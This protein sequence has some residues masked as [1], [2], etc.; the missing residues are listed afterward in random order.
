MKKLLILLLLISSQAYSCGIVPSQMFLCGFNDYK[1]I[2]Y[3]FGY[4]LGYYIYRDQIISKTSFPNGNEF[5]KVNP[6]D[7]KKVK[8]IE[9][10]SVEVN[11]D[12]KIIGIYGTTYFKSSEECL[13]Q[14]DLLK[15]N[16]DLN[17][18]GPIL[19]A[20]PNSQFISQYIINSLD[21]KMAFGCT[22]KT[23]DQYKLFVS[24]VRD[25]K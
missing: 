16:I 23:D 2:R 5:L 17:Y 20:K 8:G 12:K 7:D 24:S 25:N 6:K 3:L 4:T 14:L 21:D 9:N 11:N 13:S 19:E 1:S 22:I 10:Y 15:K 18:G